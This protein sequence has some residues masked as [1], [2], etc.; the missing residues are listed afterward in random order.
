MNRPEFRELAPF[1]FYDFSFNNVLRG[2][3]S[4]QVATIQNVDARYE[5][6]PSASELISFGLFYKHFSNPI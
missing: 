2:N 4:L 3:D 1:A 6:Y 5:F